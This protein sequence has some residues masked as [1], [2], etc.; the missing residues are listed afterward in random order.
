[1]RLSIKIN[2]NQLIV[3]KRQSDL[4]D[5][6]LKTIEGRIEEKERVQACNRKISRAPCAPSL[7]PPLKLYAIHMTRDYFTARHLS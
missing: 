5:A 6:I 2:Y 4:I 1:M 7:L 3:I